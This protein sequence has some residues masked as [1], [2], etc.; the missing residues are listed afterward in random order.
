MENHKDNNKQA[1]AS[2]GMHSMAGGNA[3]A[4]KITSWLTGIY[5]IIELGL[6]YY[7]GS[8][9]V[10]SDAFH[11]FSAVGGVLLALIAGRIAMRPSDKYKTFGSLRAEIIGALLNGTFLL[12]MAIFILFMGYM[13]LKSPI[14]LHI[15]PMLVAAF[16]GLIIEA[17]SI[18]LLY[19]GQKD[20]LNIRGAFWHIIQ[21]F[22]GSIIII[23]SAV[24]IKFTGFLAIDP[25]LGMLF[26]LVLF[27]ASWGIIR[28]SFSIL[29]ES[30]PKDVD[31]DKI[32][33]SLQS[34]DGVRDTHHIHAWMLTSGKNIFSAH[35][36]IHDI[37]KTEYILNEAHKIL[38]EKY[39]FYFSTV[40]LELECTDSGE[41]KHI[42]ITDLNRDGSD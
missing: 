37:M 6:G 24:V 20:N 41:A 27:Y 9:A 11:T 7:S 25:I 19:S 23:V 42:D 29:L 13:R 30:V 2:H 32:K 17:I 5:F 21:T 39:K 34:I 36:R 10:I 35:I 33:G 38:K 3:R 1:M 4:L 12:V 31:L 16:G 8:I 26:G 14:E 15:A 22:V 40:Q 18:K 28:D